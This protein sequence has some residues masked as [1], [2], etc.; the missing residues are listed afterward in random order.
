MTCG[1]FGTSRSRTSCAARVAG[2]ELRPGAA[3]AERGR[4]VGRVRRQP[5]DRPPRARAAA[6]RAGSSTPA[7]AS[8]GSSPPSPLRQSLGRLSTIE[9]QMAGGRAAT[10]AARS[11]SSPSSPPTGGSRRLLGADQVLRVKRL[12]LADGAAVRRGDGVVPG[13]ARPAPL[14]PRRRAFAV[15]RA[16]RR[17]RSAG[18]RRRSAPTPPRP[19]TPRCSACRPDRRCCAATG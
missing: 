13:R 14:P 15:L 2:G 5:G 19:V 11:S 6:R 8:V 16:A 1:R 7:R 9:A 3:P 4:A 12:N 18:R 10:G 17:L